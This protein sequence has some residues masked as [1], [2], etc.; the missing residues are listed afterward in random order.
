M[1]LALLV[2]VLHVIYIVELRLG[3]DCEALRTLVGL[4]GADYQR[5]DV[6]LAV[7]NTE[8]PKS[9][10]YIQQLNKPPEGKLS[11]HEEAV[12]N[13]KRAVSVESRGKRNCTMFPG[14][15]AYPLVRGIDHLILLY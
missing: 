10:Y 9:Q 1:G 11:D 2:K 15:D 3:Y 7:L 14:R 5:Q 8:S 13:G 4:R 12:W 6:W